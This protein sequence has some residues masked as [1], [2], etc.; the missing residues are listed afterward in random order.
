MENNNQ[1]IN[2]MD[3][4]KGE[5]KPKLESDFKKEDF[6]NFFIEEEPK[7]EEEFSRKKLQTLETIEKRL[8][9]SKKK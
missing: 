7:T 1:I 6:E 8:I 5:E 3:F 2:F 4:F 9:L